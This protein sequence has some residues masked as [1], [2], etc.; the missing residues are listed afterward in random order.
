MQKGAF[1]KIATCTG[2]LTV[3]MTMELIRLL[4]YNP[5]SADEPTDFDAIVH[6][7]LYGAAGDY[8]VL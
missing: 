5:K 2:N 6:H 3:I 4:T 7:M 8:S 1:F